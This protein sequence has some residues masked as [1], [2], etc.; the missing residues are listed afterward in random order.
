MPKKTIVSKDG[1]GDW[2]VIDKRQKQTVKMK[3]NDSDSD[4]SNYLS[5]D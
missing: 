4:A 2:D 5:S 1:M 3:K